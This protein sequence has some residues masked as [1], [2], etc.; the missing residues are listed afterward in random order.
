MFAAMNEATQI[1]PA[2]EPAR[3]PFDWNEAARMIGATPQQ[4][5]FA[6]A[7]LKGMNNT[8]AAEA[9][10]YQ[11][12]DDDEG[13]QLRSAGYRCA[14]SEKVKSLIAW[15]QRE[16][17]GIPD[18]PCDTSE[19]KKILSQTARGA[20]KNAA[21][22]AVEVLH[23]ITQAEAEGDREREIAHTPAETLDEIAGVLPELAA[24]LAKKYNVVWEF[25][26]DARHDVANG[27]AWPST[28]ADRTARAKEKL[29]AVVAGAPMRAD[30]ARDDEAEAAA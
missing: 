13:A 4:V 1:E 24:A 30:D 7:K 9:A 5:L 17:E 22:R 23:R 20:D 10:G 18:L 19:L 11:A 25:K 15:A 21:I 29:R 16:G 28:E 26:A 12:R 6:K 2:A 3:A 27:S 14:H 8:R